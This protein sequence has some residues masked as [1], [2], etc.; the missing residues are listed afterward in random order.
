MQYF[1]FGT[2]TT[3]ALAI[4][5]GAPTVQ[6]QVTPE[7]MAEMLLNSARKA[8]NDKNYPFAQA[9]FREFLT[10]FPGHKEAADARYGLALTLIE[11]PE[12]KFEEARDLLQPLAAA[13]E[14]PDRAFATY[15][16][17]V[18]QRGIGLQELALA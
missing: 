18:A 9:K 16:A 17:G 8:H 10:K 13:K 4:C 5:L 15:Y 14:F 7:Q 2:F 3:L 11:G 12:K 1:G 6:A